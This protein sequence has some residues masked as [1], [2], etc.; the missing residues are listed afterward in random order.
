MLERS[1]DKMSEKL[2]KLQTF[3]LPGGNIISSYCQI[4]R[5][6]CRR[7]ERC[8]LKI[9]GHQTQEHVLAFVNRLSD[10]LFVLARTSIVEFGGEER[11][12][13]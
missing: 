8:I 1:I 5:T 6:V 13:K 4:S 12:W 10:Y 2:P 11:Y 9:E 3:V 7:A